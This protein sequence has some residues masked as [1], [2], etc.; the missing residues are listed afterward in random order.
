MAK[1][2]PEVLKIPLIQE[3]NKQEELSVSNIYKLRPEELW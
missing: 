2:E 3:Y 1:T